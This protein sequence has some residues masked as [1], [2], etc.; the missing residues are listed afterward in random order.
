MMSSPSSAPGSGCCPPAR[1]TITTPMTP[2]P[3][4]WPFRVIDGRL[5]SLLWAGPDNVAA[6]KALGTRTLPRFSIRSSNEIARSTIS[7]IA[8]RS[9]GRISDS[10]TD[11]IGAHAAVQKWTICARQTARRLP[12]SAAPIRR[13]GR[14]RSVRQLRA[15]SLSVLV[16][17]RALRSRLAAEAQRQALRSRPG[18]QADS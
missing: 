12:Q 18:R 14:S 16:L 6:L 15:V 13:S 1:R 17:D 11:A 4:R 3:L 10:N 9:L 2:G 5:A 8:A 7:G